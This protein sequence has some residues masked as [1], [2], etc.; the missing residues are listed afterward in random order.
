MFLINLC[1]VGSIVC[2]FSI[3][4]AMNVVIRWFLSDE[5]CLLRIIR[6][7][8]GPERCCIVLRT[9]TLHRPVQCGGRSN[10]GLG[11][12]G[13]IRLFLARVIVIGAAHVSGEETVACQ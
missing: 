9:L 11:L 6:F 1:V 13:S 7:R 2:A 10:D 4:L 3:V 8:R 5:R 12:N